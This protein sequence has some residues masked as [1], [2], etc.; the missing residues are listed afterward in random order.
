MDKL[1]KCSG[2]ATILVKQNHWWQWWLK[3]MFKTTVNSLMRNCQYHRWCQ[4]PAVNLKYQKLWCDCV[5]ATLTRYSSRLA[6]NITGFSTREEKHCYIKLWPCQ[7]QL[8]SYP[9][10]KQLG[11]SFNA[12]WFNPK[13][14]LEYTSKV[15]RMFCFAIECLEY[16]SQPKS[17]KLLP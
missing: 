11:R 9:S 8:V 15:N 16:H 4:V 5:L 1:T 6:S 17:L 2:D 12:S 14:L 13:D 3:D 10:D 7:P